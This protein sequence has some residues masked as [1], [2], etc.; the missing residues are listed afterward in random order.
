[1]KTRPS[2]LAVVCFALLAALCVGVG[3]VIASSDCTQ[4][5]NDQYGEDL[6]VCDENYRNELSAASQARS[7]CFAGASSW[8]DY[9]RCN[10]TYESEKAQANL[11]RLV[12]THSAENAYLNCLNACQQSPMAP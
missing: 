12:C 1:M 11:N 9:L 5:C 10:G 7:E 2:K 4:A 6:S 3:G 8:L